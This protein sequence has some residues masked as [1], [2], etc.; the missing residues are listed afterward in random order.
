[1]LKPCEEGESPLMFA[2]GRNAVSLGAHRLKDMVNMT[3]RKLTIWIVAAALAAVVLTL[4][5][6][7]RDEPTAP[8]TPAVT[9]HDAQMP[10]DVMPAQIQEAPRRTQDVFMPPPTDATGSSP[11]GIRSAYPVRAK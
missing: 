11:T 9:E 7:Q 4:A 8:A 10:A 5:V 1:M 2:Q 3:R 6:L